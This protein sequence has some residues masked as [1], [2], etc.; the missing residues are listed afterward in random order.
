MPCPQDYD[1]WANLVWTH[2][3]CPNFTCAAVAGLNA[4]VDQEG[5]G[6]SAIDSLPSALA[7]GLVNASSIGTSFAR[8]FRVRMLL[9]MLDPPTLPA[10]NYISNSSEWVEGPAH[11]A[12][13]R[14]AARE[15]MCVYVNGAQGPPS[16]AP[17]NK[18]V[19]AA[20]PLPL[21]ATALAAS[22]NLVLVGPQ[23]NATTLL[24]GNYAITP[25]R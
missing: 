18:P 23:V 21:N 12:L 17:S 14:R 2:D 25:D 20:P 7:T 4:G 13:A 22:R 3:Y 11:I 10:W 5:G 9:G 1:A 6:T 15:A 24:L 16:A 8:L 19:S